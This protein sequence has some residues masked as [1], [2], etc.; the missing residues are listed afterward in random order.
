MLIERAI[1]MYFEKIQNI[2]SCRAFRADHFDSKNG[3]GSDQK[4]RILRSKFRTSVYLKHG[5]SCFRILTLTL[6]LVK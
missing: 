5:K 3:S 4:I 2:V 1:Q 6:K